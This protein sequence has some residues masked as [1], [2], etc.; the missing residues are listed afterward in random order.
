M[1]E[2]E[3]SP[4]PSPSPSPSSRSPSPELLKEVDELLAVLEEP[5][6]SADHRQQVVHRFYQLCQ[7]QGRPEAFLPALQM[8]FMAPLVAQGSTVLILLCADRT[9]YYWVV[10]K[11]Q[12][13]GE[14]FMQLQ[15]LLA[16]LKGILARR[17]GSQGDLSHFVDLLDECLNSE[18]ERIMSE[19]QQKPGVTQQQ[20]QRACSATC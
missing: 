13:Y 6:V 20:R 2:D 18:G 5:D 16:K 4:S 12:D 15:N 11:V 14:R 10:E 1:D 8:H 9:R 3:S 19:W 17:Q 7:Q